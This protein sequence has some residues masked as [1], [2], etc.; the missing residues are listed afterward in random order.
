MSTVF[1]VPKARALWASLG[2]CAFTLSACATPGAFPDLDAPTAEKRPLEIQQHGITRVDNYGWLRDNNWQEVLRDPTV[3][4]ADVRAHLEAENA[5]YEAMTADLAPL[6]ETLFSEM[7]GRIQEDD[8]TVPSPDGDW[9]YFRRYREGGDYP[10]YVRTPREGGKE[11]ILLDGDVEAGDSEF[12]SIGGVNNSPDHRLLAYGVDRLGSEYY[13]IRVR[14]LETG[15]ELEEV[16]ERTSG[17][18]VWGAD[19]KSFFYTERDENQ[20][21]RRI[22]H[23]V[24]GADPASDRVVYEEPSDALFV[25]VYKSQSGAYAF[26][27][28]E[29][30]ETSVT[31]Y[32]PTDDLSAA[33][34]LIAPQLDGQLY[35]VEHHGD[36]FYIRTNADDAVDFKIVSAPVASPGR[37]NWKDWLPYEPGVM[38]VGFTTYADHLVRLERRNANN[39][40]VISDYDRNEHAIQ[41]D[42][43]AYSLGLHSGR[44]FDTTRV[45]FSFEDFA[46]PEQIF[47]YDMVSRKRT[48]RKTQEVPSGHNPDLY[49]V[50]RITATAPDGA[51]IPVS[52]L[53]LKTTPLDGS[54]PVLLYGYGSY[55]VTIPARFS[56]INLSMVDRGAIYALAHVRG[57]ASKGWQWY[58]DGKYAKKS[59]T[60][61]DFNA[62]AEALIDSDYTSKG[63]I[64][65][66]G[67]SAGGLLV[68]ASVNLQPDLFAGI[69]AAVPFVDVINTISDGELPLTPPEW[70][71]WGDP[72]TSAE[73]YGWIA[74]YSP[75][76]N[77][78]PGAA[79]PPIFATG[80]LTDYRVTYW[81]PAKWVARLRE[82]ADGGPFLMRMNMGAGHGGSAARFERLRDRAHL[83]AFAL[84]V[85]G[86]SEAEP[87]SHARSDADD[88][89]FSAGRTF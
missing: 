39:E 24:L 27:S 35:D 37:E 56:T 55:G 16:I 82:E 47:D 15:D 41:F 17:D 10:V 59:N 63:Q 66:F 23:H 69:I 8:S 7:R 60:F 31:R 12:F 14:D 62:A 25:G 48:L 51:A 45:R 75:Y 42:S 64:V 6:R 89:E 74:G 1:S 77:I 13:T 33:P 11:Q 52:I 26:I 3:L 22:K 67:G 81:E 73:A 29:N 87:V 70:L 36:R 88:I 34:V 19:S 44:E 50:E 54:A 83:F 2:L 85:M 9:A 65:S 61:T 80:G 86:L 72:I 84:N 79:Y 46:Q 18:V 43:P 68:G 76:D 30:G 57:G 20:R 38:V 53:R 32:V 28:S 40:I 49:V 58:L 71:E 5:Y 78:Q 4:R 21:P